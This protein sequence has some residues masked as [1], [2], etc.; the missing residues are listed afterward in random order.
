MGE[1]VRLIEVRLGLA[2]PNE[3]SLS[4][5]RAK[6]ARYAVV[7]EFRADLSCEPPTSVPACLLPLSADHES[8]VRDLAAK[9][10]CD[11]GDEYAALADGIEKDLGLAGADLYPRVGGARTHPACRSVGGAHA[12]GWIRASERGCGGCRRGTPAQLLDRPRCC[13][14]GSVGSV[15]ADG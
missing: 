13:P 5:A 4:D 9:V 7:T 10:R 14:S 15:P 2:L 3:S 1:L 6:T 12:E 11:H 8:R